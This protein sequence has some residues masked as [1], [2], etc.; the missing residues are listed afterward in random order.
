MPTGH[1]WLL[2]TS[3]CK[4]V[5]FGH[6][7]EKQRNIAW[8]ERERHGKKGT[9]LLRE[10]EI[11]AHVAQREKRAQKKFPVLGARPLCTQFSFMS[12]GSKRH[13]CGLIRNYSLQLQLAQE[14]LLLPIKHLKKDTKL[15]HSDDCTC[16]SQQ[17]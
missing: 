2:K 5:N 3:T 1:S 4:L 7:Q 12:C 15:L 16:F 13:R 6:I 10:A 8:G 11:T 14:G 9:D 17:P